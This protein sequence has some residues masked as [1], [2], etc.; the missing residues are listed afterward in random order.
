VCWPKGHLDLQDLLA[1]LAALHPT[2]ATSGAPREAALPHL[3]TLE[4]HSRRFYG[5]YVGRIAAC[6]APGSA[7]LD[8][9]LRSIQYG[10]QGFHVMAGCGIVEGSQPQAEYLEAQAKLQAILSPLTR[11]LPPSS[12]AQLPKDPAVSAP[13]PS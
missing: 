9:I 2:P 11:A 13:C 7:H 3:H 6:P 12:L 10:P 5:G 1:T 4:A 8:V